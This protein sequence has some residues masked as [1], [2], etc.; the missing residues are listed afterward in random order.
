MTAGGER[1]K[2][3]EPRLVDL[4]VAGCGP[5]HPAPIDQ[6]SLGGGGGGPEPGRG[7]GGGGGGAPGPGLEE[8][9]GGGG[10]PDGPGAGGGGGRGEAPPRFPPPPGGSLKK[11]PPP[12]PEVEQA[13]FEPPLLLR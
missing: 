7:G 6:G 10:G 8:D 12:M 2:P 4:D 9:R 1:H 5:E 11:G 13:G 3:L